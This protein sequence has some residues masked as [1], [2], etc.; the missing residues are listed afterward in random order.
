[1]TSHHVSLLYDTS[2]G[3]D[4]LIMVCILINEDSRDAVYCISDAIWLFQLFINHVRNDF[5]KNNLEYAFYIKK[6]IKE[7]ASE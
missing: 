3:L 7:G 5:D 4:V 2:I 6:Y 1:M